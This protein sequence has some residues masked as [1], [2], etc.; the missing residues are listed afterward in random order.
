M[1]GLGGLEVLCKFYLH[2]HFKYYSALIYINIYIKN[3]HTCFIYVFCRLN[4]LSYDCILRSGEEDKFKFEPSSY[5]SKYSKLSKDFEE[6]EKD[7]RSYQ[8][9][10][11]FLRKLI[12]ILIF[13]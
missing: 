9:K 3:F 6:K 2:F 8:R 4:F 10:G 7:L 11:N 5:R 1:K 12:K 13:L